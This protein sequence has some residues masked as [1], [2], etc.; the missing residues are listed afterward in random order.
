MKILMLSDYFQPHIGGGVEGVVLEVSR[1]LVERGHAVHLVTLKVM[2]A[3][4]REEIDGIIVHRAPALPL[5]RLLGLQSTVSA[6]ALPLALDVARSLQP[7]LIHA[8]NLFFSTTALAVAL[9]RAIRRPLVT[10]MH[11]GAVDRLGGFSQAAAMLYERTVGRVILGSS[12]RVIA[13]SQAV[14]DH[15]RRLAPRPDAVRTIPNGVD[16]AR[17]FPRRD[18][19]PADRPRI[20]LVGRL[21]FNKGP[22]YLIDAAPHILARHPDVEFLI[23]GDGP[24][25]QQLQAAVEARGMERSFAFLGLRADIPALLQRATL[26][27]RPSLSEGLPLTVLE[28]MACALPVVATPVGGTGE[29]V[30]DGETGY[31]VPPGAAEPLAESVC[32]LLDHPAHARELGRNGRRIVEQGYTWQRVVDQTLTLYREL[33]PERA[34]AEMAAD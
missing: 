14:A 6:A 4:R 12:D 31:L 30:R 26:L 28:A 29:I 22:Q 24:M 8:H 23:V 7:D 5:T 21:I 34:M 33:L 3:P 1:G 15:G 20:A 27:V 25:R 16:G 17:F 2:D 32:R 9:K 13:V 11:L 10:T 19:A 18:G